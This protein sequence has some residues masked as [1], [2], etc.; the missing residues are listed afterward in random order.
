[1]ILPYFHTTARS[2][3]NP[4]NGSTAPFSESPTNIPLALIPLASLQFSSSF[5]ECKFTRTPSSHLN[6]FITYGSKQLYGFV[7]GK[8]ESEVSA[9]PTAMTLAS[10]TVDM[11]LEELLGPPNVPRSMTL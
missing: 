6:A 10:P 3:L 9:C 5:S 4:V 11:R 7:F 8:T 2:S 1:M